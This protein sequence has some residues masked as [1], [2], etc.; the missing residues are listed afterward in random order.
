MISWMQKHNKYLIVTIWIATIAF[1]GA[2]FVGWGS[3]QYGSKASSIAQVGDIEI[4]QAKLDMSYRNIYQQ[5]NQMLQGKLDDKKAK[6]MGL[7]KQAFGSLVTQAQLLNLAQEFGIIVSDT[8]VYNK[9]ASIPSFQTNNKLDEK[10]YR[11]YLTSQR[12]KAKDF[13]AIIRDEATIEKLFSLLGSTILPYEEQVLK[14]AVSV[15]DKIS[16]IVLSENDINLTISENNVKTFWE[17]NKASYITTKKY[18]MDILWTESKDTEVT[19]KEISDHYTQNSF[20][21]VDNTGK[22]Q[23]LDEARESVTND[24]KMKKSKK[25]AQKQYIAYKKG[26]IEKNETVEVDID[27]KLFSE[28][29]WKEI[30]ISNVNDIMKP[31][32]VNDRYATIKVI[33][34][35]EPREMNFE[36]AKEQATVAFNEE[37]TTELL[38]KLAQEKFDNF[39]DNSSITSPYISLDTSDNLNL[40]EKEESLQFI[41][42][43]FTSQERSGIIQVMNK[44]IVY[45]IIDQKITSDNKSE[46]F[47]IE[48][49]NQIK[50]QDFESNL[51]ERMGKKYKTQVF[52]EGL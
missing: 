39:D 37:K 50:K 29:I 47:P 45:K 35:I 46:N 38:A 6:E 17:K 27:N 44:S 5:Y 30:K 24:I 18:K 8:E 31:K 32:A 42:K 28:L 36:E 25:N 21:Y 14:S 49:M 15:S 12:L 22:Q 19:E 41:Q 40:L 11:S 48:A 16:Y 34:I 9:I 10:I 4:K 3:Y 20:N 33:E 13:E 52:V 1:I 23:L 51:I 26:K 2:G 7:I 43:L